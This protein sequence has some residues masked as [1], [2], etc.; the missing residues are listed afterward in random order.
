MSNTVKSHFHPEQALR[1]RGFLSIVIGSLVTAVRTLPG[2]I[3]VWLVS[4]LVGALAFAAIAAPVQMSQGLDARI[5]SALAVTMAVIA[6]PFLFI[7][8]G[9]TMGAVLSKIAGDILGRRTPLLK[10][11]DLGF[12]RALPVIGSALLLNIISLV[13]LAPIA[14]IGFSLWYSSERQLAIGD[15]A[16]QLLSIPL[17]IVLGASILFALHLMTRLAFTLF[18]TI[19]EDIGPIEASE[20]AW[21][22]SRG[23]SLRIA[24]Y[25][26]AGLAVAVGVGSLLERA[27]QAGLI[28][29]SSALDIEHSILSLKAAAESGEGV[30]LRDLTSLLPLTGSAAIGGLVVVLLDTALAAGLMRLYFDIRHRDE[31]FGTAETLDPGF[32]LAFDDASADAEPEIEDPNDPGAERAG[33]IEELAKVSE[34]TGTDEEAPPLGL[35]MPGLIGGIR[36][37]EAAAKPSRLADAGMMQEAPADEVADI[38]DSRDSGDSNSQI[39]SENSK[40]IDNEAGS[41]AAETT[42]GTTNAEAEADPANA[43]PVHKAPVLGSPRERDV[44]EP[45]NDVPHAEARADDAMEDESEV[46]ESSEDPSTESGREE[47]AKNPTM[48]E[49]LLR[50]LP[51]PN[52]EV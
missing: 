2:I 3:A 31:G 10:A 49:R 50:W 14:L 39:D 25:F 22:L 13:V 5:A 1:K 15:S 41:E 26:L 40:A 19:F 12:R 24:F 44:P 45:S 17:G 30:G 38:V 27:G 29:N 48:V 7:W 6:F 42:G 34:G 46:L 11:F 51:E 52:D 47:N 32:S 37:T 43:K 28:A 20:R 18:S 33:S 21:S 35:P 16:L 4:F 9:T 23:H 36:H 8:A